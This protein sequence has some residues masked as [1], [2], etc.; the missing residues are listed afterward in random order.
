MLKP[1]GES[2]LGDIT[3]SHS[4][5]TFR[6]GKSGGS[7][8]NHVIKVRLINK[9]DLTSCAENVSPELDHEETDKLKLRD[10]NT[11]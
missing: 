4:T 7:H 1:L 6:V 5:G 2:L 11:A 3:Q 10:N 8:L 9:G